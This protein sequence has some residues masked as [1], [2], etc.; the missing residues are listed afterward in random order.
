[1]FRVLFLFFV[2]VLSSS[3][4]AAAQVEIEKANNWGGG[5][6][7]N[8][9][10]TN[11]ETQALDSW[12][13]VFDADFDIAQVW[14]AE[15]VSY[16]DGEYRIT[17]AGWNSDIP[18]GGSVAFGFIATPGDAELPDSFVVESSPGST[19]V[20][21]PTIAPTAT[22]EP[23]STPTPTPTPTPP[24]SITPTV[25][26]TEE[27]AATLTLQENA[28][29][30]C[31]VDEGGVIESDH[32]GFTG[33]GYINT[34]NAINEGINWSVQVPAD[35]SYTLE[36]RYAN[37]SSSS[38][39]TDIFVNDSYDSS[40]S[41]PSTGAWTTYSDSASTTVYL[42]VGTNQLRLNAVTG[43]GL[44]NIDSLAIT[45]LENGGS[46]PQ[47]GDC[48]F[49]PTPTP[50]P[51]PVPSA[52]PTPDPGSCSIGSTTTEW[53]E[54][55]DIPT[56]QCV[57]GSWQAPAN[58]GETNAPLRLESEHFAIY[59]PDGTNITMAAAQQA[60]NT[61]E[62]IWS[63]YFGAP[64]NFPEPYCK[65]TTKWKA[66]VHFDNDFPL[67]GGG[68]SRN[69][70]SYMGMWIGPGAASDSWGLAHEFM[71]GVQTTTQGFGDCGGVGCWIYESH[72]N[73]MPHQI[74]RENVHCSEMLVNS[75]HLHYGNTRTR[76]CNW[77]FFEFLKDKHCPSAVHDMWAYQAPS[78]QRDPWQKLML[79]RN[80][81][82]E[83]LNNVFGEWAMH[84]VTW[85]YRDPDGSDQ[86]ALYRQN[87]GAINADPGRYTQRR[88]RLTQLQS[89]DTNWS[90]NR[91]F[92]SPYYWAPQRWGYNVIRLYPENNASSVHV[93]FRGV[94]QTGANSGWRWGLVA[95]DSSLSSPR[96]SALQSGTDGELEF[97][98][99][100]G[101]EV[102]LVVLAAPTRYQKIT[103]QNPAD[104]T[105]YPSIY[106]YPYMIELA[107]AWP[108]GFQ[109]GERE[110]CPAGTQRHANGGGC[111][112]STTPNSVYVGPYAKVLGGSVSANARIEDQATVI[113]GNISGN[114]VVG[115]MSLIGVESNSHHGAAR[116]NVT[117]NAVVQSTFY[118]MGW[119]GN[120]VTASGSA[121]YLGDLEAYASKS[122]NTFFGL[123]D[124][125]WN[126]VSDVTEVTIA[127]PYFWRD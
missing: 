66:A 28:P 81:D 111:A 58:G 113:S 123:V 104:G 110:A 74:F 106:R 83:D 16:L 70:I 80:W 55:C 8:V 33:T 36:I 14:N 62:M 118:P 114:A 5:F 12:V 39:D 42:N 103:W 69:G 6:Q 24:P 13:I 38:R 59:W 126:G 27:P 79:S 43:E 26:P 91:R 56:Q 32:F 108:Q 94:E 99:S 54:S 41:L 85:D 96:Y 95:T 76:Y 84:N 121:R 100:P 109:N 1:M 46:A 7:G 105:A 77:Q 23:T 15:I 45:S 120:D 86:G 53:A 50:T 22:P 29:G 65:S 25:L 47:P 67:W 10:I 112:T 98:I 18:V 48:A 73:W 57:V 116:F 93:S 61:L 97:C 19:P 9:E 68:W 92:V 49:E 3:L 72:A 4:C 90:S 122:S 101:E 124:A 40:L 34:E 75:S 37:G 35:G 82:I 30:F 87:Y 107:G 64:L 31:S 11:N 89:L 71:H 17:G 125:G 115:A 52:T 117:D 127:P 119:F 21:T 51:T 2:G 20:P 102:Y 88:Q 60:A 44:P 63:N 78:G